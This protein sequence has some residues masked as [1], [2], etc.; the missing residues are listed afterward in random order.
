MDNPAL[1]KKFDKEPVKVIEEL[2]GVD[3]PDDLVEKLIDGIKAKITAEKVG[4][5]L[6]GLGKLFG[7]YLPNLIKKRRTQRGGFF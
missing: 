7:T 2:I 1:L 3:L 5:A 4:D 6:E